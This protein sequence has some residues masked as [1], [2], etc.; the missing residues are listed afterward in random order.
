M[1]VTQSVITIV[2]VSSC[3]VNSEVLDVN[4][5]T[6]LV[7][8]VVLTCTNT[9]PEPVGLV[10]RLGN[11][12]NVAGS[13][14]DVVAPVAPSV[15]KVDDS[16]SYDVLE[17]VVG[18]GIVVVGVEST[19]LL[20]VGRE[21]EPVVDVEASDSSVVDVVE[22]VG[23]VTDTVVEVILSRVELV[24]LASG[25]VVA[26]LVKLLDREIVSEV[27]EE[28]VTLLETDVVPEGLGVFA[29][30][31]HTSWGANSGPGVMGLQPG[32]AGM[33]P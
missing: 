14:A 18:T 9:P 24:E 25:V 17:V 11:E 32:K 23:L 10:V 30:T 33:V 20:E 8:W 31:G 21:K 13:V 29:P 22:A 3:D 16:V 4:T 19:G 26:E 5:A 7:F 15:D 28:L 6:G 1:T 2:V 12:L 27:A